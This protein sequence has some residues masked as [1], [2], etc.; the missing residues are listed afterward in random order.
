MGYFGGRLLWRGSRRVG[1]GCGRRSGMGSGFV[2]ARRSNRC[3]RGASSARFSIYLSMYLISGVKLREV[4][5]WACCG[6]RRPHRRGGRVPVLGRFHHRRTTCLCAGFGGPASRYCGAVRGWLDVCDCVLLLFFFYFSLR[7]GKW[8]TVKTVRPGMMP[9]DG[10]E[11][12]VHS[13]GTRL[14]VTLG[15]RGRRP[16]KGPPCPSPVISRTRNAIK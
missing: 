4:R 11:R 2:F 5:R 13:S 10:V 1:R 15:W 8:G 7:P 3:V 9:G 12:P 6:L 14:R 16:Q